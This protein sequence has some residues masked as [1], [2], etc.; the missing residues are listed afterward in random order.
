MEKA[1]SWTKDHPLLPQRKRELWPVPSL[2]L[3]KDCM[4]GGTVCVNISRTGRGEGNWSSLL[5]QTC[6]E[7][8]TYLTNR[9]LECSLHKLS[10]HIVYVNVFHVHHFSISRQLRIRAEKQRCWAGSVASLK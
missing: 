9:R 8:N 4:K 2:H 1:H 5:K 7:E 10:A 3:I 6:G